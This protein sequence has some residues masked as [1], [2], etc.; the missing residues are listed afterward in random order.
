MAV[1]QGLFAAVARSAGKVFNTAFGWATALLFGKVPKDRQIYL[2]VITF[3]AVIWIVVLLGVIFPVFGAW[4]LTFVKPPKWVNRNW[5][6]IAMLIAAVIIP[7]AV[8]WASTRAVDPEDQ[9]KGARPVLISMVRGYPYT[10]GLAIA[11]IM[12]CI[13]APVMK[14]RT[15]V[16]RWTTEHVPVIVDPEDYPAFVDQMQSMLRTAGWPTERRPASWMVRL[17]TRVLTLFAG[18]S[19]GNLIADQLTTLESPRLEVTLHPSDLILAAREVDVAHVQAIIA[20]KLAFTNAYMTW[21]KEA[22]QLEDRLNEV[23]RTL[24]G[25]AGKDLAPASLRKMDAIEEEIRK[26]DLPFDEWQVID[27][28]KL[29]VVRLALRTAAGVIAAPARAGALA[30]PPQEAEHQDALRT[31]RTIGQVAAAA[32]FAALA[33]LGLRHAATPQLPVER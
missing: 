21:S 26:A 14:L 3:G 24:G 7:L 13:F 4:M 10:L 29:L 6:R 31:G 17:P 15:A 11:L 19:V 5:I 8:G 22:N 2:S 27:R 28:K 12:M 18:K 33:W 23:W 25:A 1:I 20:E 30:G 16:R 32:L 9:P